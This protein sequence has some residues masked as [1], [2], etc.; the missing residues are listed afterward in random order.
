MARVVLALDIG[1]SR[2]K[3]M[4]ADERGTPLAVASR[5]SPVAHD[6]ERPSLARA[7][8]P[9]LLWRTVCLVAQ[10]ALQQSGVAAGQVAAVGVTSQRQGAAFLD[11]R[12]RELYVGPSLDLRGVFQGIALDEAHGK[13][14]YQTTGHLP[15]LF[16]PIS[17]LRWF[18]EYDPRLYESIAAVLPLADWLAYRLTGQV[19]AEESLAGE[20]GLLDLA[21]RRWATALLETLG[22][23]T[24]WFPPLAQAGSVRGGLSRE[25]AE[26]LGL[27][28]GTPVTV[29]GADTQAGLLALGVV[30]PGQV[31]I[32]AGWS[33][34]AQMV[35]AR[36]VLD[37][38]QRTWAGC[39]LLPARWVCEANAGD[40][41]NAYR[42]LA[43]LLTGK[44]E[45]SYE[46]LEALAAAVPPGAGGV[47]SLL[48][49][50]ALDLSRPGLHPG[51]LL[52]PVPVTYDPPGRG[53]L[54]RSGLENI[55]FALRGCLARLE[56]VTGASTTMV[57]MGGGMAR[58][59]LFPRILADVLGHPVQLGTAPDV[60]TLG[61]S[62]AAL[63]AAGCFASLQEASQAMA[64]SC[65]ALEPDVG[66]AAAYAECYQRWQA[67]QETLQG[68]K[69]W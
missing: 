37:R 19:A 21:Q 63:A 44:T 23:R 11:C 45:R 51:G 12:G 55:A 20:A 31:G 14:I 7:F 65:Q 42:W 38:M 33:A 34:T 52:L 69:L 24:D 3:A 9:A 39:H 48:G 46:R 56:E 41:G 30:A 13:A 35:T 28:V 1:T 6:G 57:R 40:A 47:V 32:V 53:A 62:L 29:G 10:S 67:A 60:S 17:R 27:A 58:T 59:T 8:R 49:P 50:T 2:V 43:E 66:A 15:S 16:F 5:R 68:V 64:R 54:A 4:V 22:L 61:A 25:A 26:A 36:P 18:Q